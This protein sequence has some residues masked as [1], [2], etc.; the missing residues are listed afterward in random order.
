[1]HPCSW[2]CKT[3][4]EAAGK[5]ERQTDRQMLL[6]FKGNGALGGFQEHSPIDRLLLNTEHIC[7]SVRQ[8]VP[9]DGGRAG[10]L[11]A[12]RAG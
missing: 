7:S 12:I 6:H 11:T 9:E 3:E 2:G 8:L 10:P 1:M 4:Q 5:A